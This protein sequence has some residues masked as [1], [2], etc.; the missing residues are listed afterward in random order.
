MKRQNKH[1]KAEVF[2]NVVT[3]KQQRKGRYARGLRAKWLELG[4]I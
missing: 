4:G 1:E 2:L 3:Q